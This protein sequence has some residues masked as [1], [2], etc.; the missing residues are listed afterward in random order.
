[1]A[2]PVHFFAAFGIG[3]G[4]S[5]PRRQTGKN[6]VITA[7][8]ADRWHRLLHGNKKSVAQSAT[9]IV[10]FQRCRHWQHDVGT[11][12]RRRPP[13][14]VYDDGFRLLPGNE[15]PVEVLLLVKGIA[16]GPIDQPDIRIHQRTAVEFKFSAG[17]Q[18]HVDHAGHRYILFDVIGT[19]RQ[20]DTR[21]F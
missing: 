6:I 16:A 17:V 19:L 15:K 3:I 13:R 5:Q 21:H 18:Q 8:L 1:M 20:T 4:H 14:F 12:R 2:K 9:D 10:S 7:R 11:T